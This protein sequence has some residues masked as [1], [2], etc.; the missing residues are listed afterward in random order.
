MQTAACLCGLLALTA[1]HITTGRHWQK[2][3]HPLPKLVCILRHPLQHIVYTSLS[4]NSRF[5][6]CLTLALTTSLRFTAHSF[7]SFLTLTHCGSTSLWQIRPMLAEKACSLAGGLTTGPSWWAGLIKVLAGPANSPCMR[8]PAKGTWVHVR[9]WQWQGS[10]QQT[11]ASSARK[12]RLWSHIT[13]L[14]MPSNLEALGS[15]HGQT[16]GS[17]TL[18][19]TTRV[20]L[21]L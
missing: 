3:P 18:L 11:S 13:V 6:F 17:C 9:Q 8:P 19:D 1:P 2:I 12:C 7:L 5:S 14:S 15:H 21:A 16:A 4:S 20:A 10:Q